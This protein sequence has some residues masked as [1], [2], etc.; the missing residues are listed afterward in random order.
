MKR[1]LAAREVEVEEVEVEGCGVRGA[2]GVVGSSPAEGEVT[3][4]SLEL[5]GL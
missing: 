4:E 3:I 1:E 2:G 5:L